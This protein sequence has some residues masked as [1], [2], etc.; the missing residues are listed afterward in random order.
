MDL[1][2]E[3]RL[4]YTLDVALEDGDERTVR[5]IL[6]RYPNAKASRYAIEMADI[7]GHKNLSLAVNTRGY[8]SPVGVREVHRR[9]DPKTKAAVWASF[10]PAE[11][12]S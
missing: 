6:G 4:E 12:R 2:L 3:T 7:N 10:I 1:K 11:Y 5:D 8:R 9:F